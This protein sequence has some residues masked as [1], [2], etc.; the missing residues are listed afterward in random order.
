VN[1]LGAWHIS[2]ECLGA[3]HALTC[4]PIDDRCLPAKYVAS[5]YHTKTALKINSSVSARKLTKSIE[6]D[7]GVV[8]A[9]RIASRALQ[10]ARREAMERGNQD[11]R[12]IG[13]KLAAFQLLNLRTKVSLEVT[14]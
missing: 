9:E 6:G 4:M 2:P 5:M 8:V 7:I 12:S 11:L 14:V 1:D 13:A 10:I 3:Q